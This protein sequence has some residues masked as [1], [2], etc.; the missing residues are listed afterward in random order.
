MKRLLEARVALLVLV[1]ALVA[2][3]CGGGGAE[4]DGDGASTGEDATTEE[5]A[6]EST[7]GG[8]ATEA[9]STEAAAAE[10]GGEFSVY[11]G[12]PENISPPS[13]VTETNGGEITNAL[14]APLIEYDLEAGE[15]LTGEDAPDAIAESIESDDQ[16][17]W[18]VTLKEGW[19]F[20]DGSPVTAQNYVDAFNYGAFGENAN[21]GAYF[22]EKIAG[23]EDLQ[24]ETDEESGECVSEP[25]ATEMTGLTVVDDLTF[26]VELNEPFS[27][28]PLVMGYTAFN[29]V[30]ED[31]LDDPEQYVEQ[32]VGTGQYMMEEPWARNQ[33]INMVRYEDYAGGTAGNADAIEFRIYAEPDTAYNDLLAGNLDIMDVVPAAQLDSAEAEFGERLIRQPG[34]SYQFLGFPTYDERFADPNLR[35]AFA[36]AIDRQAIV[37][38]IRPDFTPATGFVNPQ[39][40][41]ALDDSC[42]GNCEFNV[43]EAQALLEEAGG[44]EGTLTLW[45]NSGGD[46]EG[47]IE[48]TANQL[49]QNLGIEAVEFQTLDFAEYLPLA[50]ENG[51]DG[52]YRLGWVP[53]YPSPETYLNPLHA[54]DASSNY[55]GYSS[56]EFDAAMDEGDQAEDPE[57]AIP[58]Y[59]EAQAVLAE[60]MPHIPMFF[61]ETTGV[62]SERVEG[63][64]ISFFDDINVAEITV[65][66]G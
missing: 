15:A 29:P 40:A 59:E 26:T 13:N 37:D 50:Q 44:F 14:Y 7:D 36:M 11:I 28:W 17:T 56:E 20:H 48:A 45:F 2:A 52:P 53:D 1:L 5:A 4:E 8:A 60:D 38:A 33:A 35:K 54:T 27:I 23:Y 30:P 6:E 49:T 51:F 32:P 57:G 43:E 47:W 18:T 12:E 65:A 22:F 25:A 31:F 61:A 3:A 34:G 63:V 62:Y 55:T 10:G 64:E 58:S 42:A 66:D 39:V 21:T 41:G 9:E 46:H 19:T 24:C 16:T